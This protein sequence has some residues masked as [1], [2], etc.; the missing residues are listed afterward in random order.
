MHY[1]YFIYKDT[2]KLNRKNIYHANNNQKKARA[3]ILISA[4]ADSKEKVSGSHL[5]E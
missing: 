4:R 3:A 5:L 2:Y 1:L